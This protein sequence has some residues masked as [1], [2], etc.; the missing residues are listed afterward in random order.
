[1]CTVD[2]YHRHLE[3]SG[4]G[5][6]EIEQVQQHVFKVIFYVFSLGI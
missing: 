3:E 5:N 4:F 6:I 1:M 2:E